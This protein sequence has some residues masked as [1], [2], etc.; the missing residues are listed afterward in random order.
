M[1][2]GGGNEPQWGRDGKELFYRTTDGQL[3]AVGVSVTGSMLDT[4]APKKLFATGVRSGTPTVNRYAVSG[5]GSRFLVLASDQDNRPT[6]I[7]VIL[8]WTS[9]LK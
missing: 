8:N 6:P 7:T 4:T 1:S 5:D 2:A 9:T 3:M